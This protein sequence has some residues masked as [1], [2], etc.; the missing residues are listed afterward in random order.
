MS[1]WFKVLQVKYCQVVIFNLIVQLYSKYDFLDNVVLLVLVGI[2]IYGCN[3]KN[4]FQKILIYKLCI[5]LYINIIVIKNYI[6][7]K[8]KFC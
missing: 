8:I 5:L 4:S 1:K 2:D 3:E 7:M 6:L